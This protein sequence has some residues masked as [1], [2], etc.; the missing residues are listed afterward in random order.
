MN[1][2]SVPV[3]QKPPNVKNP[4]KE[5]T[6]LEKMVAAPKPGARVR[7][8]KEKE[9]DAYIAYLESKLG[10]GKGSK[11]KMSAADDDGLDGMF[12]Y[13]FSL[14]LRP[15]EPLDLLDFTTTLAPVCQSSFI[16]IISIDSVSRLP[17]TKLQV[18]LK[19]RT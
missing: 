18:R 16:D 12:L 1:P 8:Q 3:Q 13:A 5:P 2:P 11:K 17:R 19:A 14:L 10:Y 15:H 7:T 6:R 9:E 4:K